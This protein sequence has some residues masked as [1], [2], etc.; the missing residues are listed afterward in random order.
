MP[1]ADKVYWLHAL[2]PLHI[3]TGRGE[4]YID[5]PLAREKVTRLPYVPGSS[6]KGVFADSCEATQGRRDTALKKAAFGTA[7][8]EAANAGAL[9]FTDARLVCLPVRSLYGTFAWCTSRFTLAR[10]DRDLRAAGHRLG[11]LPPPPRGDQIPVHVSAAPPSVLAAGG[12]AYL[13]DLDAVAL[14]AA[15]VS[16]VATQIAG[17]LFPA[18]NDPWREEFA[19]R[20]AV[21]PDDLFNFLCESGT[22]VQPHVR[23]EDD[24]KTVAGGALWYEESLPAEA[25]LA[26]LVWCDAVRG[27]LDA[28]RDQVLGLC[29]DRD[30]ASAVQLGGKASVGKGRTRLLF[31]AGGAS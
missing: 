11:P 6:V 17:W 21:L 9:V 20:F 5:L 25:V 28:T 7:G 12:K 31:T 2:S 18:A 29:A 1:K 8:D 14:P 27:G 26:G 19:R 15:E 22:E 16:A 23:I 10:L 4:G 30:G 3:G 24:T 13:E